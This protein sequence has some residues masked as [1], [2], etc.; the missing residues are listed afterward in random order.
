L[1]EQAYL[2][3]AA[4]DLTFI[5]ALERLLG[6]PALDRHECLEIEDGDLADLSPGNSSIAS[7]CAE[8]I[9]WTQLVLA[10]RADSQRHHW[11]LQGLACLGFQAVQRMPI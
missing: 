8:N 9:A 7:Q 11:R 10:P 4:F 5:H 3:R 6:Y 1:S 2:Q